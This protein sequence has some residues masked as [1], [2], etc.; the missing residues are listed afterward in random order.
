MLLRGFR[1]NCSA[2][3][4]M[5]RTVQ[6]KIETRPITT[7]G[8]IDG[9]SV[10]TFHLHASSQPGVDCLPILSNSRCGSC[11]N[12]CICRGPMSSSNPQLW[13]D[14]RAARFA[15]GQDPHI[16][17]ATSVVAPSGKRA[18]PLSTVRQVALDSTSVLLPATMLRERTD[19]GEGT[20][21]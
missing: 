13:F 6:F 16:M 14:V 15:F 18:T 3:V 7:F 8:E 5:F 1:F 17:K 20:L 21:H 19:G 10:Q 4:T 2:N 9:Q 12:G 11:S